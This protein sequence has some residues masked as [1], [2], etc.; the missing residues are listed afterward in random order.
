[1]K[2]A[3]QAMEL[4][5]VPFKSPRKV[6]KTNRTKDLQ[7]I[8]VVEFLW[9]KAKQYKYGLVVSALVCENVYLVLHFFQVI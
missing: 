8:S 5:E 9:A 2:T 3:A 7:S 6:V 1:M 4:E